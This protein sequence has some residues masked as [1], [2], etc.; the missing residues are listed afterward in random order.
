[1]IPHCNMIGPAW[2]SWSETV[3]NWPPLS[4]AP[5]R[6]PDLDQAGLAAVLQEELGPMTLGE[7]L[8]I[9]TGAGRL[10]ELLGCPRPR[11]P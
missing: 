3:K 8:D 7:L 10:L 5:A 1:M 2:P 6:L 4:S 9:G 11:V